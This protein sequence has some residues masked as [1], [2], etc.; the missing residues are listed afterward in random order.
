M[1]TLDTLRTL[2]LRHTEAIPFENLDPLLGRPVRLDAASL[3][4][5]LVL[6]GRG[7]YCYEQNLLLRHAL[8][9]LGFRVARLAARVLWNAPEGAVTPLTHMM[10][11]VDLGEGSF[12]AD[13]GFGTQ[14]LL[15]PVP[16]E[17]SVEHRVHGDTVRLTEQPWDGRALGAPPAFDL[18]DLEDYLG[19]FVGD[20]VKRA[21]DGLPE[22]FREAIALRD[23]E[24]FS[25]QEIA[26]M[27]EIPIGTVM[28]RL[29]RGR[30]LLQES[31]REYA[32]HQGYV[33]AREAS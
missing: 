4:E 5:K 8:E 12:L 14:P 26:D 29:F 28:S 31:L 3:E 10:L 20:E 11:R 1:P 7:G 15:G 23:M 25:Y 19:R 17:P 16:F 24:G 22:I 6:G 13:V 30:R 33:R 21:V 32:V 27:L 18:S 2:V 9:A